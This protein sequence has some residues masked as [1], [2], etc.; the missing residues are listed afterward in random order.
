MIISTVI[1]IITTTEIKI[2][3]TIT[4]KITEEIDLINTA[5]EILLENRLV[6]LVL[7]LVLVVLF[8]ERTLI[9]QLIKI[10][11]VHLLF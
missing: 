7:C 10:I 2:I 8:Q 11:I 6:F 4:I 9:N 5:V 3:K 1:L